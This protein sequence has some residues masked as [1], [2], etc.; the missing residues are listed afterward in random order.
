MYDDND[1]PCVGCNEDDPWE[2]Q[3]CMLRYDWIDDDDFDP[4]DI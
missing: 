2:C 4:M 1:S 3:Y